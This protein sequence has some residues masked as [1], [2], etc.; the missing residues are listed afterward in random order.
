MYKVDNAKAI[1]MTKAEKPKQKRS[2]ARSPEARENEMIALAVDL[3]EKKLRDGT[4]PTQVIVHYLKLATEREHLER[5]MLEK[6]TQLIGAQIESLETAKHIEELYSNAIE[7]MRI[8]SGNSRKDE[9][10]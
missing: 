7:A 9:E 5:D 4:A 8:Y 1:H 6:K 2:T 3:A 10:I